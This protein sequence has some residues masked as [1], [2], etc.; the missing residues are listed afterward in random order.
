[1]SCRLLVTRYLKGGRYGAG[2]TDRSLSSEGGWP[3]KKKKKRSEREAWE[4]GLLKWKLRGVTGDDRR[5]SS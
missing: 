5:N 1:M 4:S 2:T 3:Q